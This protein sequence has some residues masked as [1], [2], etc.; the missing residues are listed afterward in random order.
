MA[1]REYTK[2]SENEV[3]IKNIVAETKNLGDL[4]EK[5]RDL[6]NYIT[7]RLVLYDKQ[8][9]WEIE[10]KRYQK[11]KCEQE[12]ADKQKE[13]DEL[14]TDIAAT[15][16][17]GVKFPVPVLEVVREGNKVVWTSRY[18]DSV[19]MNGEAT[20]VNGEIETAEELNFSATGFGKEITNVT[21]AK[22]VLEQP[23]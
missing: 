9:E 1:T 16:V 23:I 22:A 12:C 7:A 18:A 8:A 10:Q 4:K 13:L 19:T 17:E 2:V 20:S 15:I 5:A 14:N 3:E 21:V 6:A 11:A